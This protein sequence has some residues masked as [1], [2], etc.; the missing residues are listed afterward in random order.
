M[1]QGSHDM[2]LRINDTIPNLHVETDQ[3]PIDLHDWVGD[4]WA[5]LFLASQG[6]HPRLHHRV[7]RRRAA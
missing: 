4:G 2:A 5:V 6:L 3:G 7:R 1:N